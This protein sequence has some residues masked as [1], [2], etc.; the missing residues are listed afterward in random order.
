MVGPPRGPG[1]P[2]QG[3]PGRWGAQGGWAVGG[4]LLPSGGFLC[5]FSALGRC[6]CAHADTGRPLRPAAAPDA[7]SAP[8]V[9]HPRSPRPHVP[10]TLPSSH[11]FPA[12]S[13][14]HGSSSPQGHRM[15]S[16]ETSG[17]EEAPGRQA[18]PP[19]RSGRPL[20]LPGEAPS[21]AAAGPRALRRGW[22]SGSGRTLQLR[23]RL[24]DEASHRP[25]RRGPGRIRPRAA[26]RRSACVSGRE[27][28]WG[29]CAR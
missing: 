21:A 16:R 13:G 15:C 6:G 2:G 23:G 17:L 4:E 29:P 22:R 27:G 12:S 26:G 25:S 28:T 20:P 5:L 3:R 24:L 18:R 10:P 8:L 7:P 19:G 1:V 11:P 9:L 14:L